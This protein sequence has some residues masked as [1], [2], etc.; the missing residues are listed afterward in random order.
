MAITI[1][2]SETR[3]IKRVVFDWVSDA[4][5][6][7][8]VQTKDLSGKISRITF[9]PDSGGTQPTD[10]YTALI[11][12]EDA[13]DVTVGYGGAGLSNASA[14][15]IVPMLSVVSSGDSRIVID[16]KLTLTIAGA[17]NAKGG[18]VTIYLEVNLWP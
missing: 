3:V 10:N 9:S 2:Y 12:D 7:A 18:T 16:G 17:G 15:S 5:G 1:S 13:I 14:S 11:E 4:S 8:T 6:D